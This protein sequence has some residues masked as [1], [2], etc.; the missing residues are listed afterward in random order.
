MRSSFLNFLVTPRGLLLFLGGTLAAT[1]HVPAD[2]MWVDPEN[3]DYRL[4]VGSR[5][6][7]SGADTGLLTD[8]LLF[9]E[10]RMIHSESD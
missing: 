7:G 8:L 1:I 4:K 3:G 9:R 5:C 6:I 10:Q 2:P